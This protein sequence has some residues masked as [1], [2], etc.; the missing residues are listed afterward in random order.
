MV[1]NTEKIAQPEE[2]MESLSW[3]G[4]KLFEKIMDEAMTEIKGQ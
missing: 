4:C 3:S 1:R 2:I